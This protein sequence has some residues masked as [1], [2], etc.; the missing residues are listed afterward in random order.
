MRNPK[1]K[2]RAKQKAHSGSKRRSFTKKERTKKHREAERSG[3]KGDARRMK[4]CYVRA[5]EPHKDSALQTLAHITDK[6]AGQGH[7]I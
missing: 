1:Y 4:T 3:G 7:R 5:R 2:K 6:W